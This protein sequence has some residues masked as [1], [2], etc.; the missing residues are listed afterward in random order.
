MAN[1]KTI[2]NKPAPTK[3]TKATKATTT[4]T[5]LPVTRADTIL[6][7]LTAKQDPLTNDERA[8]FTAR[9]SDAKCEAKGA[10]T[11]SEGV[12][13]DAL[14]W[15]PI[16]DKALTDFPVELRRYHRA[17]FAWFLECIRKLV[18]E[19]ALQQTKGGAAVV[20]K[21]AVEQ[22]T[23]TASAA[24]REVVDSLEELVE[25]DEV[26]EA[27]LSTALGAVDTPDRLVQSMGTVCAYARQWL[28]RTDA[29][30]VTKVKWSGLTVAEVE[31]AENAAAT[32]AQATAGKTLEGAVIVRD[33][34]AVNRIEG[35]VL[36]EMRAAMRV[37]SKANAL[38]KHIPKLVPG[39][40]TRGALI[41]RPKKGTGD[42]AEPEEGD[43]DTA[44]PADKKQ[45][46]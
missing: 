24:R 11:K 44:A 2:Q 43:A 25:G 7:A 1:T 22:A 27:A 45:P 41:S 17:R 3:A 19:R 8:L 31:A 40:A 20:L 12:L 18:D 14:R 13:G 34:P 6:E 15:A 10:A 16:I 39:D 36:L 9:Y 23:K 30:S 4:P 35:R 26:E 42:D 32:L 33:T 37:F 5:A 28:R 21:K 46:K 38:N 29:A